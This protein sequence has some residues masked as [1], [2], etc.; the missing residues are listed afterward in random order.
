MVVVD[1]QVL[2][3]NIFVMGSLGRFSI[4]P[5]ATAYGT[6]IVL[7][8]EKR[9]KLGYWKSILGGSALPTVLQ[10]PHVID[11]RDILLR[12][13]CVRHPTVG[14]DDANCVAH[15][16]RRNECGAEKKWLEVQSALRAISHGAEGRRRSVDLSLFRRALYHLSYLGKLR[17]L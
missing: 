6:S 1:A 3:E 8:G 12:G 4:A 9:F 11:T 7:S 10:S 2:K 5:V 13:E 17:S 15:E 14:S 16:S